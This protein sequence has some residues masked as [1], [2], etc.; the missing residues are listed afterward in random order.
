MAYD[1]K[2]KLSPAYQEKAEYIMKR[3]HQSGIIGCYTKEKIYTDMSG[4]R[5]QNNVFYGKFQD[6]ED[7]IHGEMMCHDM[8]R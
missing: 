8:P 6:I 5:I 3:I 1:E 2:E 4:L 7:N